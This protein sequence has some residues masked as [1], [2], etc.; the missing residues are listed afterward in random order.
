MKIHD[1][2]HR[3]IKIAVLIFTPLVATSLNAQE[4]KFESIVL[5]LYDKGAIK[6]L[7]AAESTV[8][9]KPMGETLIF[10]V[11]EPTL[12]VFHPAPDKAS[13][14]AVII[15][16]GGG[17]VALAYEQGGT[18]IAKRL[19]KA[20]VTAVMLKYRT[21]KS[22]GDPMQIPD[23]HQ[24]EMEMLLARVKTG[25]PVDVP[26]FAGEPLALEDGKR[27]MEMVREHASDWGIDSDKI[28]MLGLSAGAFIA[29][30]LAVGQ[31]QFRPNFIGLL[32]GGL[33]GPV[34]IDAPPAFIAAAADD[35]LLPTDSVSIFSSWRAVGA[36]A[37]L[38]VYEKG[39]HGFDIR[40]KGT[41]SDEW[42]NQ[43]IKWM[44]ARKLL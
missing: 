34:P 21:I 5:P 11:S 23:V 18:A 37:E 22:S 40:V 44:K 39:G 28:G 30:D 31:D 43:F 12:E 29:I 35:E 4:I 7:D 8:R 10:N 9:L 14:T 2:I 32:Y 42:F 26:V 15:A 41:T 16:P 17:F 38:H 19:A 36:P 24:A 3:F 13:G 6:K 25:N 1:R 20:G 33:R 27:A